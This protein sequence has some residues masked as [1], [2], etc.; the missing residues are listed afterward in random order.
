MSKMRPM[1][2]LSKRE[3]RT[4]KSLKFREDI[5]IL[6]KWSDFT[7]A[8]SPSY[9]LC[10]ADGKLGDR[11]VRNRQQRCI[12]ECSVAYKQYSSVYSLTLLPNTLIPMNPKFLRRIV[13]A[14]PAGGILSAVF[15]VMAGEVGYTE[16]PAALLR[17]TVA[18]AGGWSKLASV[19]NADSVPG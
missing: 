17:E 15:D 9:D 10:Y 7:A 8:P 18:S 19:I 13:V 11:A 3:M 14:V 6:Y 5:L 4:F 16:V 2:D 1:P 12:F